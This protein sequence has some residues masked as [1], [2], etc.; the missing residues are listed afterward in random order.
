MISEKSCSKEYL[1][2]GSEAVLAWFQCPL[3]HLKNPQ[4]HA[5][6][7]ILLLAEIRG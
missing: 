1:L 3:E 2:K 5:L 7:E 4:K 6:R